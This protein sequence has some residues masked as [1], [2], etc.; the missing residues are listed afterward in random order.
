[1]SQPFILNGERLMSQSNHRM[2]VAGKGGQP[3]RSQGTK[4]G[5]GGRTVCPP[6]FLSPGGRKR[7]RKIWKDGRRSLPT[8]QG[9]RQ[10][11]K[12]RGISLLSPRCRHRIP[13]KVSRKKR[14]PFCPNRKI[15]QGMS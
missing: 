6:I 5:V 7:T 14:E 10:R 13:F 9:F 2:P 15:L 8:K 4:S 1:M 12:K 11:T 3:C